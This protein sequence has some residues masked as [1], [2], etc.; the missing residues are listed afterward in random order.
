M[1]SYATV[2]EWAGSE[3][4]HTVGHVV[5]IYIYMYNEILAKKVDFLQLELLLCL[6]GPAYYALA[7]I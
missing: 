6:V 1:A 3:Q 4:R 7:L 2:C 5:Y